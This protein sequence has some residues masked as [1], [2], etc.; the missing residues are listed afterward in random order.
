MAPVS[1]DN[2]ARAWLDYTTCGK[3]HSQQMRVG[4]GVSDADVITAFD[5]VWTEMTSQLRLC[6]VVGLRRAAAGTNLSFPVTWTGPASYGSGAGDPTETANYYDFVGRG[7]TG[8]R[9]RATFFGTGLTT[10]GSNYRLESSEST[11]VADTIA[12]LQA[13]AA[14]WLDISGSLI[15]W[16]PYADMGVNAYWRNQIR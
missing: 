13:N 1:P 12:A 11:V 6:T 2:T 3:Q 15:A 5:A 14:C 16:H 9:A 8:K 7:V 4:A 10:F